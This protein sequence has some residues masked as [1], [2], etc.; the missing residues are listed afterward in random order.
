MD[1]VLIEPYYTGSHAAWAD[2]L[3]RFS[4]HDIE[5][6]KLS[7]AHWKWRMHGGAVTM[8][9]R[10]MDRSR[11]P[12]VILATDMLDLTTFLGLTRHRAGGIPVAVYFHENQLTYPWSSKDRDRVRNSDRHYGFINFTSALAADHVFFNSYYHMNSFLSALP[13]FLSHFPDHQ[14]ATSVEQIA[15]RSSV[16]PLGMNLWWLDKAK[17][18]RHDKPLILWNHRWEYDKNPTDFFAALE[19]LAAQGR[20]FDVV[21]AGEQF[22]VVPGSITA[23]IERLGNRVIHSG[24]LADRAEYA[25]WLWRADLLPVTSNQDF[26]G[27]AVVE[28]IYCDCFPLLPRRLAYPEL[29]NAEC[30]YDDFD[31]LVERLDDAIRNIDQIRGT[32]LR[33]D[34]ARFDWNEIASEY[35]TVLEGLV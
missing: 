10:F 32:S 23:G 34:V 28:A 25:K 20:D 35:D 1:I 3:A 8:A 16:L 33:D 26:F 22:D 2:G 29:V 24:F 17:E 31:H 9:R 15:A 18:P 12:D 13:K 14:E 19:A 11:M 4:N 21:V 27:A 7:G 5:V 6:M 30:F